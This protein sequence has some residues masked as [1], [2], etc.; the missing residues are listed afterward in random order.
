MQ[1]GEQ[2]DLMQRIGAEFGWSP[3]SD[4]I[5]LSRYIENHNTSSSANIDENNLLISWHMEHIGKSNP[6]IG[7]SWNMRKF[8]CRPGTG[9][10][11]FCDGIG[12]FDKLNKDDVSFLE[13]CVYSW[14][15]INSKKL[16]PILLEPIRNHKITG[17]KMAYFPPMPN[18]NIGEHLHQ[19]AGKEPTKENKD[20]FGS[21]MIKLSCDVYSDE[22]IRT[23]Q[24][25]EQN[26]VI[27]V[28]L[29][30][31]YHAVNGGFSENEREFEGIWAF[32]AVSSPLDNL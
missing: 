2:Q 9:N 21:L 22:S 8:T 27:F 17:L 18:L 32:D 4:H 19:F 26:D 31:M 7:A 10:T 23:I 20:R 13:Q 28:D 6:A 11:L 30:R 1:F 3:G 12:L 24:Q 25:W 5:I 16:K 29:T 15:P 14:R